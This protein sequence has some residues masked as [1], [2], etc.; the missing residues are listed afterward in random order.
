M[1]NNIFENIKKQ[2][3]FTLRKP[4]SLI[5][6]ILATTIT[7]FFLG[8]GSW[9]FQ[10]TVNL[11]SPFAPKFLKIMIGALTYSISIRINIFTIIL[12]F[13]LIAIEFFSSYRF[14]YKILLKKGEVV[15]ED[16][17]EFGNR[18]WELNYWGSN[19]PE[20][21]CRL[22]NSSM[23]FEAKEQD[24]VDHRQEYGAYYDL[25]TGIYEGSNY[26]VSCWVK[27]APETS[28]GF[29]LW[30]HDVRGNNSMKFPARFYTQEKILKK[31]KW[32]SS[33]LLPSIKNTFT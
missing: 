23:I 5:S 19:N 18:G 28:M 12:L 25:T 29:K 4:S 9:L 32:G 22:E 11:V 2:L 6:I 20:K 33:E 21:T 14:F 8:L 27:S 17:F 24:L 13:I 16:K 31:L 15:F 26:E 10:L 7:G 30:V 1:K 3:P